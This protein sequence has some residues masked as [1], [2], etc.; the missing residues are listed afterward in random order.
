MAMPDQQTA[1]VE[2]NRD[3]GATKADSRRLGKRS[4]SADCQQ[5]HRGLIL[6]SLG[7]CEQDLHTN[8][9]VRG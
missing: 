4:E 3:C 9:S 5:E 8:T 2:C 7:L 1:I 6:R